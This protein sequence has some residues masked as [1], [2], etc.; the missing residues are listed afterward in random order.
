MK[1]ISFRLLLNDVPAGIRF[2]RDVMQ[3]KL[4]YGDEAMG[5]AYFEI[6]GIGIE[7]MSREGFSSAVGKPAPANS[8][9]I[10]T[11]RVDD[12]DTAYKEL[13]ARGAA[14]I[15]DPA[16]RPEWGARTAHISDPEGNIVEVYTK[17]G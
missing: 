13:V 16:D 1:L 12:V 8:G 9:A 14:A 10:I 3:I 7:L 15:A 6:D 5:Y 4:S 11:F 17:L 2:W